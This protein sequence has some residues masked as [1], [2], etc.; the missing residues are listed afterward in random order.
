[1]SGAPLRR[2][3]PTRQEIDTCLEYLEQERDILKNVTVA[4]CLGR[5]AYDA[6]CRLYGIRPAKFGHNRLFVYEKIRI[7]SS[8]HPSRQNTQ[9]GRLSWDDWSAVFARASKIVQ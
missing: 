1:M 8:Y 2:N 3:R 6:A 5:I 9:T 7:L 4:M